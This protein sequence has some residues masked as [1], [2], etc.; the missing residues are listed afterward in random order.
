MFEVREEVMISYAMN[1][2]FV[3]RR[4]RSFPICLVMA[5]DVVGVEGV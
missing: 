5:V 4:S 2:C 3:D 1:H